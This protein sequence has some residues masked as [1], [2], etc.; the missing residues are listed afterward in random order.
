MGSFMRC[1][2][3]YTY[4]GFLNCPSLLGLNFKFYKC[5]AEKLRTG[6][7]GQDCQDMRGQAGQ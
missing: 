6:E 4:T 1:R 2:W 7:L 3:K 5:V